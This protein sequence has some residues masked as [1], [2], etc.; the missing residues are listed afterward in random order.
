MVAAFILLGLLKIYKLFQVQ[1]GKISSNMKPICLILYNLK[2][3]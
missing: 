3:D 1:A 2:V